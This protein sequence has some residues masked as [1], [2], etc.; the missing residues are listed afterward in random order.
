ML[1]SVQVAAASREGSST[2]TEQG[3]RGVHLV[4]YAGGCITAPQECQFPPGSGEEAGPETGSGV[5][6]K[7]ANKPTS[8]PWPPFPVD[9]LLC[10]WSLFLPE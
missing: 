5:A 7:Q 1:V 8:R 10:L 6:G 3:G 4:L 2:A 9:A